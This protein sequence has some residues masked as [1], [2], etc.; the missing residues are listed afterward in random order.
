MNSWSDS[1]D[2]FSRRGFCTL[3]M[4]EPNLSPDKAVDFIQES[5]FHS[6]LTCPVL[7]AHSASS[8]LAQKFLESYSAQGLVL[9]NPWPPSSGRLA[10]S[11]R[12]AWE[13]IV[14][15]NDSRCLFVWIFLL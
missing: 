1:A 12:V 15:D 6:G 9:V 7:V 2:Y 8:F 11:R 14:S 10:Q 13:Q 3:S 5:I 4:S